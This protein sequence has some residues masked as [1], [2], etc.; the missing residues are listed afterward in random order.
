MGTSAS[1]TGTSANSGTVTTT[2]ANALIFGAG[3]T[4]GSFGAAPAPFTTRI[5]TNPDADIAQDR[6][7]TATGAYNATAPLSGSAAWVMQVATFRAAGAPSGDTRH[8]RRPSP[9]PLP[10]RP[11]RAR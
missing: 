5:I 3:M 6:I 10:T 2:A 1:G 4:T 11:S 9:R 8:P 7:V